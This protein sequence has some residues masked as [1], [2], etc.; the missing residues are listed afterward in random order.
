ME[1]LIDTG[2]LAIA[3]TGSL[4]SYLKTC[5]SHMEKIILKWTGSGGVD[6]HFFTYDEDVFYDGTEFEGEKVTYESVHRHLK[7]CY[8][9]HLKTLTINPVSISARPFPA[10]P[11]FADPCGS[12]LGR[13]FSAFYA[14]YLTGQQIQKYMLQNAIYYDYILRFRPDLLIQGESP[15]LQ[16]VEHGKV[17]NIRA[18]YDYMYWGQH[19]DGSIQSGFTDI[20]G[21]GRASTMWTYF[22]IHTGIV[23]MLSSEPT[24][25]W[26]GIFDAPH[27]PTNIMALDRCGPEG[28]LG[29]WLTMNGLQ[30]ETDWRW[31]LGILRRDGHLS[32]GFA[33]CQPWLEPT[34]M[35]P[36]ET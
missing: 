8:G 29:Y 13:M 35:C 3:Y 5:E 25:D 19:H 31:H 27:A 33:T 17:I 28:I 2:R 23:A 11:P 16:A 32:Q 9:K 18:A 12:T 26:A 36:E 7:A 21:Y 15:R 4:R 22:N 34:W 24:W 10:L 6:L 14:L 20:A 1:V 30:I